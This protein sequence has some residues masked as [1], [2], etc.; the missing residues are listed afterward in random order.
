MNFP[1]E[2]YKMDLTAQPSPFQK[3]F[4]GNITLKQRALTKHLLFN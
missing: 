3:V 2:D 4:W 1:I